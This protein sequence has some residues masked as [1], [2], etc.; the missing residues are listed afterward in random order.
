MAGKMMTAGPS[1]TIDIRNLREAGFT[2]A[3]I[4]QRLGMSR[5]AVWQ[6]YRRSLRG[7][8]VRKTRRRPTSYQ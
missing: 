3:E 6:A 5:Q 7:Q 8:R 4:G 1:K 2:F